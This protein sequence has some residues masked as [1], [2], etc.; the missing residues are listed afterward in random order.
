MAIARGGID[1]VRVS[2]PDR[3]ARDDTAL[4]QLLDEWVRAGC[5]VVFTDLG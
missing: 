4:S 5:R 2:T 1:V 3:L